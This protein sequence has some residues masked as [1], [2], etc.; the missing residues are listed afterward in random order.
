MKKFLT[1]ALTVLTIATP[2]LTHARWVTSSEDD[3]FSGGK[4][5]VLI[6]DLKSSSAS[7]IFDCTK[8]DLSVAYAE[9]D[10]SNESNNSGPSIDLIL[11]I[12][13]NKA[14][15]LD[16]TFSRR[17]AHYNQVASNDADKIKII[18]KQLMEAK[19]KVLMG[20]QTKD[21]GNQF[22]LSGSV[23]NSTKATTNFIKACEIQL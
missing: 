17:N 15:T 20:I 21:G 8:T 13:A 6:G 2:T 7:I 3:I 9:E 4:K 16:A 5:A 14:Q 22:S 11:K 10:N 12:D 1:I 23:T 19:S 18:L